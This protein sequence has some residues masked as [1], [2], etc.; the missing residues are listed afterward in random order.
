MKTDIYESDPF[1]PRKGRLIAS[2]ST[3]Y[4]MEKGDELFFDDEPGRLKVRIMN[5]QVHIKGDGDIYREVLALK[6]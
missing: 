6:L 1:T 3:E 2:L 4:R 5:V